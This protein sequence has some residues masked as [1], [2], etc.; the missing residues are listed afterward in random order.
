MN[1]PE[2]LISRS[3]TIDKLAYSY[4]YVVY[5]TKKYRWLSGGREILDEVADEEVDEVEY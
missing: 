3:L 5:C 1:I 2:L 4:V